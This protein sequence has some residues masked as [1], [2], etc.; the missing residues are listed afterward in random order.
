MK[1]L[2]R[3]TTG[4]AADKPLKVLQFGGGNFLRAF[5]DWMIDELNTVTDFNAGVV[6]AKPTEREDYT[7]LRQQEGLFHVLTN[8]IKDGELV[9]ETQL[10][11]CVQKVVH[12]YLEWD[13]FLQT[14]TLPTIRFV[15]SNTTEAGIQV[16]KK[17]KQSDSPPKE[18]PAKLTHWLYRRW[19]HF[20]GSPERGC[21]HLPCELIEQNGE[22]LKQCLLTYSDLWELEEG[23]KEWIVQHNHF[24]NTLVDRIVPGFPKNRINTVY[25]EIGYHDDLVVDAEPYH[26]WVIQG[27]AIV[28]REL[29][30]DQTPLNVVFTDD[31]A[32]YRQLKVRI[33]NGAHTTIVPVGYLAGID[34][35]REAVEDDTVGSFLQKA[36]FEEIL[37]TLDFPTTQKEK[38]A[39]DVLDRFK[40][41][42]IRHQL[43]SISLNS[44]SK[45]KT[46]VLP[47]LLTYHQQTG[48]LP[49]HLVSALAHL[50]CFYQGKR[51][52]KIIPLKDSEFA[53]SFFK[54]VWDEWK[55]SGKDTKTLVQ[56]VL[57]ETSFWG[58]DLSEISG[59][60][61]RLVEEI[62]LVKSKM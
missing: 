36:L 21:I 31:L 38:Y 58:N 8:G 46:R 33:L 12:P 57:A 6:I 13:V 15:V 11:S 4:L 10:I 34:T 23:F 14:A 53:L 5:T 32:P 42:F 49:D 55:N 52:T 43:I 37:P 20:G 1:Q 35:V 19:Q 60:T 44:T 27:P 40:N 39:K 24:C 61:E 50:I 48:E 47:S 45:F 56:K 18:F 16:D 51:G 2:N 3:T 62:S 7:A 26:I 41:P 22:A 28:Q 17:D 9:S 25:Q 29:P 30:F 54:K 59:L